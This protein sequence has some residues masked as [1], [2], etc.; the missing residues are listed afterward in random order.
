[1]KRGSTVT[2]KASA[3]DNVGVAKV[4]FFVNGTLTCVSPFS[5]Y[6]CSWTVPPGAGVVYT[7]TARAFDTSSNSSD[8]T[9]TVTSR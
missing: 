3:T 1:V 7:I 2:I 5:P 6:S 4:A 8:A 9:I